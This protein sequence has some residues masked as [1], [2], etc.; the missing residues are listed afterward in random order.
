MR[1]PVYAFKN[2]LQEALGCQENVTGLIPLAKAFFEDA[3]F[4][5]AFIL[6]LLDRHVTPQQLVRSGLL[7]HF[8]IHQYVMLMD[9]E[10]ILDNPLKKT[11]A[12]LTE[13][14]EENKAVQQLLTLVKKTFCGVR[15]TKFN[16]EDDNKF[17]SLNLL[18]EDFITDKKIS[19]V[20]YSVDSSTPV[21]VY[22]C[23]KLPDFRYLGENAL[24]I[25]DLFGFH[26]LELLD[27]KDPFDKAIFMQLKAEDS[28]GMIDIFCDK[29]ASH[30]LTVSQIKNIFP[31]ITDLF[32]VLSYDAF[33]NLL[34]KNPL[35]L[36][37]IIHQPSLLQRIPAAIVKKNINNLLEKNDVYADVFSLARLLLVLQSVPLRYDVFFIAAMKHRL[38]EKAFCSQESDY[39]GIVQSLEILSGKA[40]CQQKIN[41]FRDK[42]LDEIKEGTSYDGIVLLRN[43]FLM[44]V[45]MIELI[46]P[47]LFIDCPYL[48]DDSSYALPDF[49]I[50]ARW[51]QR[52]SQHFSLSLLLEACR[53]GFRVAPQLASARILFSVIRNTSDESFLLLI[54]KYFFE[55]AKRYFL[56]A[57]QTICLKNTIALN[58]L[59]SLFSEIKTVRFPESRYIAGASFMRHPH[60]YSPAHIFLALKW[61]QVS[62]GGAYAPQIKSLIVLLFEVSLDVV[63]PQYVLIQR[64]RDYLNRLHAKNTLPDLQ[65]AL[66][67]LIS[68]IERGYIEFFDLLPKKGREKRAR[69][70]ASHDDELVA[71][72]NF[73]AGALH[74]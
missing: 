25:Y 30:E 33:L 53:A 43:N 48:S 57:I 55:N 50:R 65:S 10:N 67:N 63:Q 12:V 19:D 24:A 71:H 70:E 9:E 39:R 23:Y 73:N 66:I 26:F 72:R 56:K 32:S 6:W 5:A 15:G 59:R 31:H 44:Q 62:L 34:A 54:V 14:S 36:T 11:Y 58:A 13:I 61:I 42:L 60:I 28:I 18:C 64:I 22:E 3:D 27:L 20:R 68:H 46:Y 41:N 74:L 47:E 7:H 17:T 2:K 16:Q 49:Y 51:D 1:E 37:C 29:A 38:F 40:F 45:C 52:R 69:E 21:S 8:F 4:L 35:F